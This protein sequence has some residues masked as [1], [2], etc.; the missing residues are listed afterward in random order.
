MLPKE[1]SEDHFSL[2]EKKERN[3]I[4]LVIELDN[5]NF[6]KIYDAD[7]LFENN[8]DWILIINFTLTRVLKTFA[9]LSLIFY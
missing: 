6:M 4:S 5:N 2:I 8:N 9:F 7:K 1:L 3:V